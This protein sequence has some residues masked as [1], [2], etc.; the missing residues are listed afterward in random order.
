MRFLNPRALEYLNAIDRYRSLRKAALKL[1]I[2]PSAISRSISQLEEGVGS[3]IWERRGNQSEITSAGRELLNYFRKMQASEAAT[4]SKIHDI[5]G[6]KAGE[7]RIAVGEG[8]ITDLISN[9]LQSFLERYPGI[10]LS[11]QMAGAKEA[12]QLLEDDQ[13]DFAVTYASSNQPNLY[14]HVETRHPL[15]IIAPA[16]H[17]LTERSLPIALQELTEFPLAVID[18]STGMGRLINI[19]EETEDI[20]LVPRLRTNSVSVL[21]NF[22]A[23][24]SG[25]SFMPRLSVE[26]EVESGAINIIEVKDSFLSN[27]RARVLSKKG[28]ELTMSANELLNHLQVSTKFLNSDAPD[29]MLAKNKGNLGKGVD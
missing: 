14:C 1:N 18:Q 5:I 16:G 25:I 21:K 26:Q 13:I 7:V 29:H 28:R 9:S 4:I 27:A 6:L 19:A 8:F 11:I 24:G 20:L 12:I 15:D 23:S 17:P 3:K 2:D 10:Q 22:V